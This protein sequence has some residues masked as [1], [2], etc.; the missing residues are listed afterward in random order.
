MAERLERPCFW[1]MWI[2]W[3]IAAVAAVAVS[4]DVCEYPYTFPAVGWRFRGVRVFCPYRSVQ[5]T[6]G[7][8]T[9]RA[10]SVKFRTVLTGLCYKLLGNKIISKIAFLTS[11]VLLFSFQPTAEAVSLT[12]HSF[13]QLV[14]RGYLQRHRE[15]ITI[16]EL[17]CED[18]CPG[19]VCFA[20]YKQRST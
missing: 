9:I 10:G 15:L 17:R 18:I 8:K 4:A 20:H 7:D 11:S 5:N 3:I 2:T 1:P 12:V 19:R 13:C 6:R 14:E 16:P